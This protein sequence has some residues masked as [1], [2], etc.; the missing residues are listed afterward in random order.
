MIVD[1]EALDVAWN[2]IGRIGVRCRGHSVDGRGGEFGE[3]RHPRVVIQEIGLTLENIGLRAR[4]SDAGPR[5]A[6]KLEVERPVLVVR[7]VDVQL[8]TAGSAPATRIHI[9]RARVPNRKR[10]GHDDSAVRVQRDIGPG[11]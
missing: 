1:I 2:L 9:V 11:E 6:P 3:T 8:L 7:L 5:R 4:D 10:P